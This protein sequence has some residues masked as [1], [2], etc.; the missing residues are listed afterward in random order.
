[1]HSDVTSSLC[2]VSIRYRLLIKLCRSWDIRVKCSWGT[3]YFGAEVST[4]GQSVFKMFGAFSTLLMSWGSSYRLQTFIGVALGIWASR[5]S[6]LTRASAIGR[7]VPSRRALD[8]LGHA[9]L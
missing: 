4:M 8:L 3:L 2:L 6:S 7:C 9:L 1:V 5:L